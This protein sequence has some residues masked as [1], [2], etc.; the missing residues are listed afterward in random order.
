MERKD[1]A[2]SAVS[3]L[4]VVVEGIVLRVIPIAFALVIVLAALAGAQ[5]KTIWD[6]VYTDD[7]AKRGEAASKANCQACHGDRLSGDMGPGLA[8][9]EFVGAWTGKPAFDLYEKIRTTMPQ[10]NEGSLTAK[11]AADLVAYIF[12]LNKFPSG[13]T[14][15][16]TEASA[17]G[18]IQIQARD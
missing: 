6:G 4:I 3:A 10:G 9:A 8:G 13:Q 2:A 14:E 7:Q 15:L 11:E 1:S 17:L 12:Q 18:Q 16:G 5:S